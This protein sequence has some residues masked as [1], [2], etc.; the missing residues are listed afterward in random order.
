MTEAIPPESIYSTFLSGTLI[1]VSYRST[2]CRRAERMAVRIEDKSEQDKIAIRYVNRLSDYLFLW[3]DTCVTPS[4]MR[5]ITGF[6]KNSFCYI[7]FIYICNPFLET[8]KIQDR[9]VL[10]IRA[11]I[12]T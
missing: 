10:D 5:M 9:H 2:V 7:Y 3:P 1:K 6:L 12:E 8:I 4:N 11:R